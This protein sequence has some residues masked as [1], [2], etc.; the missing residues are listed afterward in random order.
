MKKLFLIAC[1]SMF[2]SINI[3]ADNIDRDETEYQEDYLAGLEDIPGA[4]G[5]DGSITKNTD[6]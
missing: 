1:F 4:R 3:F 6:C 2:S 5:K